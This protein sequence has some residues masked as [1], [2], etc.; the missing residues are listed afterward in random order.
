M[1]YLARVPRTGVR[2]SGAVQAALLAGLLLAAPARAERADEPVAAAAPLDVF[3]E[4]LDARSIPDPIEPVNRGVFAGNRVVDRAVLD[5]VTR[6][7]G[8][9]VPGPI[10]R[11]VRGVFDNLNQPVVIANDLLQLRPRRAG[12]ATAR[13]LLNST[14]G[15]AGI[16]D[17]A[18]EA[19]FPPHR[20][21]FGQTLGRYGVGPGIYLVLPL[22][23]PSSTRDLVGTLVDLALRPDT[24]LLPIPPRLM[25]GGTWGLSERE[26]HFEA[27]EALEGSSVDFYSSIRSAYWMSREAFVREAEVAGEPGSA[28][29]GGEAPA[30]ATAAR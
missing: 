14:F 19:G 3:D 28:A 8:R 1:P 24:W 22:L 2:A 17:P 30:P 5:P 11:A 4:E 10:K 25:L 27:L 15:V 18:L 26:K 21:D 9:I 12:S 29:A 7:Y 16:F 6:L 13:F 20:A 23:G